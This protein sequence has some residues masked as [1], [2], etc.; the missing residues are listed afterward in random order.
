MIEFKV[1]ALRETRPSEYLLRF[2]FGGA[3]TALAGI[4]ASRYGAAVGGLCL[5]F[6]AIFPAGAS[7]IEKHEIKRKAKIGCDGRERGRL[8]AASDAVGAALGSISLCA[9]AWV[10]WEGLPGHTPVLVIALALLVWLFV[11]VV[12][13]ELRKRRFFLR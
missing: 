9:F 5:A 6:P 13:W 2:L 8:A 4:V 7:L 12:L 1:K 11:A 10:V 3:C